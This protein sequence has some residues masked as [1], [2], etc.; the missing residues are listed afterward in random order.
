MTG[1]SKYT[2][3]KQTNLFNKYGVF[4][5][6]SNEQLKEGL[7]D[8]KSKGILNE[9]EK[10]M[11][12]PMGMLAP[13]KHAQKVM[14]KLSKIHSDGRAQDIAENGKEKIIIRELYNYESFYTGDI[15]DTVDAL[16]LYGFSY[17]DIYEVYRK[18][19]PNVEF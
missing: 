18:E 1:L 7:E 5:A 19:L 4:F 13:S 8:L 11:R 14:N 12:L 10:L 2:Q 6:F 17:D 9:G 15:S 3:D 16:E